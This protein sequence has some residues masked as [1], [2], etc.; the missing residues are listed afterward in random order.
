VLL[1]V[2]LEL[3]VGRWEAERPEG[4]LLAARKPDMAV[5]SRLQ[6]ALIEGILP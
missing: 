5:A 2:L 6:Q 4:E 1:Y 3:A